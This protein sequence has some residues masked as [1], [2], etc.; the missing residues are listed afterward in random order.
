M[1]LHQVE[2]TDQPDD[3]TQPTYIMLDNNTQS[4]C[5]IVLDMEK[6]CDTYSSSEEASSDP[7]LEESVSLTDSNNHSEESSLVRMYIYIYMYI[8]KIC[9][10]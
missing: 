4:D 6:E 7:N 5:E 3:S 2:L 9:S 1:Q 10:W 8:Y